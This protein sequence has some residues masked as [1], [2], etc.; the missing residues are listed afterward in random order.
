[1]FCLCICTKLNVREVFHFSCSNTHTHTNTQT[2]TNVRDMVHFS[3]FLTQTYVFSTVVSYSHIFVVFK[4]KAIKSGVVDNV[5]SSFALYS[6]FLFIPECALFLLLWNEEPDIAAW[7]AERL[8][9]VQL[10]CSS[11]TEELFGLKTASVT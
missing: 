11:A 7:H 2:E 6:C 4:Q 3:C 5:C 1:M 9:N 8:A 10:P